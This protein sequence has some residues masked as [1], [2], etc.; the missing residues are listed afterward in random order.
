VGTPTDSFN[1]SGVVTKLFQCLL[2][3]QR[4][5]K[6]LIVVAARSQLLIIKTPA[7]ATHLPLMAS[8]FTHCGGRRPQVSLQDGPVSAASADEGGA[9]RYR[10]D[11]PCV[12]VEFPYE[13]CGLGIPYLGDSLVSANSK[14]I[15][16]SGPTNRCDRVLVVN[17]TQLGHSVVLCRPNIDCTLQANRQ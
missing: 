15:A 5:N 1:S 14:V 16:F 11:P 17:L 3:V 8:Q 4:P 2:R 9:P 6:E 13:L 10:A 12:S 7:K